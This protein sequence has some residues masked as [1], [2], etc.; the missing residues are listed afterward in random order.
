VWVASIFKSVTVPCKRW[1]CEVCGR[2]KARE[3]ARVLT[4]DA[5]REPP[6]HCITLTTRDPDTP[7][8]VYRE[9]SRM[10]WRRLRRRFGEIA[11]FGFIE[12]TTGLSASSGGHRRIHGHYLV[13]F[14]DA[15]PDVIEVERLVRE[16][17]ES[18]TGAYIIEVAQL[19]TPGAAMA[20]LS[21]HHQKP[22][23]A[24]PKGWSG[25]RSRPSLNYFGRPV[26]QVREQARQE[27]AIEAIAYFNGI[28][29]IEAALVYHFPSV[30]AVLDGD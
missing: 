6:T 7:A 23:Q 25:M 10:V 8:S 5:N 16:T 30:H 13:K 18:V 3:L 14:R 11:Y 22:Q 1:Q 4:I 15:E 28:T 26:W 24:P 12:F 9:A 19:I 17:W 20:Y 21:L 27:L 29:E 2:R